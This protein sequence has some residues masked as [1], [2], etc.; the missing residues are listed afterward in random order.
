MNFNLGGQSKG[1]LSLP[2]DSNFCM[3]VKLVLKI[4]LLYN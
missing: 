3:D 2:Y 4:Q 1:F